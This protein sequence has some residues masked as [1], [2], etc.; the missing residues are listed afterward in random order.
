MKIFKTDEATK[1]QSEVDRLEKKRAALG[2]KLVAAESAA[3]AAQEARRRHLIESDDEDLSIGAKMAAAVESA[4]RDV[5]AIKDALQTVDQLVQE[6][7][8]AIVAAKESAER[9]KRASEIQERIRKIEPLAAQAEKAFEQLASIL[10]RIIAAA[11]CPDLQLQEYRVI[12]GAISNLPAVNLAGA[13]LTEA[14]FRSLPDSFAVSKIPTATYAA[15]S[16]PL[17]IR[18]DGGL[19][20]DLPLDDEN[21]QGF[22]PLPLS[23]ALTANLIDPLKQAASEILDGTRPLASARPIADDDGEDLPAFEHRIAV[24]VRPIRWRDAAGEIQEHA[25]ATADLPEPVIAAAKMAGVAFDC[26]SPEAAQQLELRYQRGV[27]HPSQK[28]NKTVVELD[29]RWPATTKAAA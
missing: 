10:E 26:G 22:R 7:R 18:R 3:A 25:D 17:M 5:T 13:A 29:V 1:L 15:A 28:L 6:G 8:A 2:G 21:G 23:G 16:L 9:A 4:Q 19:S 20:A 11:D 24:L 12:Q 14:L 27:H